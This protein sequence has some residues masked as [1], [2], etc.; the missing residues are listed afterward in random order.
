MRLCT[1]ARALAVVS[2]A[3]MVGYAYEVGV[4]GPC[5]P[6]RPVEWRTVGELGFLVCAIT[7]VVSAIIAAHCP[8]W[9]GRG[10]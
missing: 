8:E 4:W 6:V 1:A 2:I 10:S 7:A 9:H 3:L 5:W